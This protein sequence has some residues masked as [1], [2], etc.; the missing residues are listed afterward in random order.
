MLKHFKVKE[1]EL[2]CWVNPRDFGTHARSFVFIHGSGG[3]SGAW[4]FQ[5]SRLHEAFNVAAVDLPG[6]GKSGGK[7]EQDISRY[8]LHLKDL[9]TVLSLPC[10]ILVGASLGCAIVLEFAASFPQAAAGIVCVGGGLSMPVNP[11]IISG[12]RAQ[13]D[14]SLDMMCKFSLARENREKFFAPLR[15]SL[16]EADVDTTAGDMLACSKFDISGDVRKITAPTL[17]ICGTEDKMM[18]PSASEKIAGSIAGAKLVLIEGAGH[19]VMMEQPEVF[20]KALS[21]FAL[22][23][24]S[25][26]G[27]QKG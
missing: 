20:N 22:S 2:A 21:D 14:L 23:L 4:S 16:G 10:P 26:A 24:E 6:H 15:K 9:L 1:N 5:Y 13:P 25:P 18:P 7:G 3:N 11:D 19:V 27:K 12:F 17:V 8:V